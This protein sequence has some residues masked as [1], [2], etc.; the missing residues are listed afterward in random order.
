MR[1]GRVGDPVAD[2]GA[3]CLL[4]RPGARFDRHDLGA[5]QVHPFD[6]GTLAA[7][8]LGAHVDDALEVEQRAGGRG[9]DTML[10]GPRLGD[11]A[12][13]SHPLREQRLPDGVV[14]L[15]RAGVGEVL[16]LEVD[17]PAKPLG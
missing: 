4:E 3:D 9:R 10:A 7:H 1:V 6:I 13:L 16:A 12:T 11:H 2:C 5:E 17:T 8:V 15:V 14:D